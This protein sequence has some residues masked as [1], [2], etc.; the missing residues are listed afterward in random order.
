MSI[1]GCHPVK[2]A[3]NCEGSVAS[4]KRKLL[5]FEELAFVIRIGRLTGWISCR[6][7]LTG[8]PKYLKAEDKMSSKID[9][10]KTDSFWSKA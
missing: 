9:L 6:C 7:R 2:I 5:Y 4:T 10:K 1:L 8:W 3:E